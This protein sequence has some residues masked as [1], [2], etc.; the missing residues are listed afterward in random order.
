V[1]RLTKYIRELLASD[2][3]LQDIWV[4]GE[5]SSFTVAASGHA[6]LTL[7]DSNARIDAVMWKTAVRRQTFVPR[8]GDNIIV[9]GEVTVYERQGRLQL[10][11]DVFQPAGLGLLQLQLEVLRQKLEAEGLF[12]TGRKR[13]LPAFPLRIGVAT[14]ATGAVWHDIQTVIGRRFPLVELVLAPTLVQGTEA[15]DQI[16]AALSLLQSQTDIDLIILARGGGSAEDLWCFNDER[17]ARAIFASRVPVV[18]AIGHETDVTIADYVADVRAATP[19]A[20]AELAVPAIEE[21]EGYVRLVRR[22]MTALVQAEVAATHREIDGLTHRLGRMSPLRQLEQ[23]RVRIA[24]L[25]TRLSLATAHDL[26]RRKMDLSRQRAVLSSLDP[27]AIL[28][29]GY[30]LITSEESGLP[31]RSVGTLVPGTRI[32]STLING[33][34]TASVESIEFNGRHG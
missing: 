25:K 2:A 1:E 33:T 6:Y 23:Q 22:R 12:D 24:A 4:E 7:Q 10:S 29:R 5:V 20:A 3:L 30:G 27:T 11:A 16:V 17:V 8:V 9:H 13:P 32:R 31:V 21:I 15:P 34:V 19:S 14:S 28:K 18:S 26:D